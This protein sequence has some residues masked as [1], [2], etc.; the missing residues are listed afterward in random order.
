MW[1]EK[2]NYKY[3]PLEL[4]VISSFDLDYISD[5]TIYLLVSSSDP[6]TQNETIQWDTEKKFNLICGLVFTTSNKSYISIVT[7]YHLAI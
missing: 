1:N 7:T 5:S 6:H 2:F 4:K 3:L